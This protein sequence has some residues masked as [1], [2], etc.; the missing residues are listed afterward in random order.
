MMQLS[1]E[2]KRYHGFDTFR[3]GQEETLSS[4][5]S[6][7]DTLSILPTSTGKSLIYFMATLFFRR[8]YP[9]KF[10]LVCSPLISLMKDQ[11]MHTPSYLNAIMLGSGQLMSI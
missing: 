10:V 1:E 9:S 4:I 5:L 6:D 11:V 7:C 2:L 8:R 3:D